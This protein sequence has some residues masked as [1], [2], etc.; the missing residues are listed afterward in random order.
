MPIKQVDPAALTP[1]IVAKLTSVDTPSICNA[2]EVAIGGR[3]DKGFTKGEFFVANAALKPVLG[4]ARTATIRSA[5]PYVDTPAEVKARRIAWYEHVA[6]KGVPVISVVQ[7]VDES[8]GTGA[9]WGEVHSNVL[10][11][12]GVS[13]AITNG[14]MRDLD[15]LAAG[16]QIL[17]GR[18]SPSHA[19]VQIVSIGGNVQIRGLEINDGD[20]L[21]M[22]RHGAVVIGADALPGLCR[23]IDVMAQRESILIEASRQPSFSVEALK[24]AIERAEAIR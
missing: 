2:L 4:F 10:K 11:G 3:T 1:E 17:A 16:F 23:G 20:L 8:P 15:V 12:L 18:L 6:G 7:D 5:L 9:F 14:A 19:F 24:L 21:H 22:D 13:G